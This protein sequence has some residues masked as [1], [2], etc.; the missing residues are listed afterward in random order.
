MNPQLS[1]ILRA[2]VIALAMFSTI[3][4]G[5]ILFLFWQRAWSNGRSLRQLI[6]HVV[7]MTLFISSVG[8]YAIAEMVA[9]FGE[10]ISW[11]SPLLAVI[12]VIASLW[13]YFMQGMQARKLQ[14][15]QKV[16]EAGE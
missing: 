5:Q 4:A 13:L 1:D 10:P 8:I 3:F 2:V 16:N 9:R 6:G 14:E 11:R 15:T 7:I 12:F